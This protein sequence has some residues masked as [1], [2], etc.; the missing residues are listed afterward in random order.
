MRDY[1]SII[2][3]MMHLHRV[4]ALSC[5]EDCWCWDLEEIIEV[6]QYGNGALGPCPKCGGPVG[7][8]P[9][10]PDGICTIKGEKE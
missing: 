1:L 5:P 8:Y 3:E 9:N 7:H 6:H 4:D 2:E 10:C